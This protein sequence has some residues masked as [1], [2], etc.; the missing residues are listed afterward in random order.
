M[1]H[2][3]RTPEGWWEPPGRASYYPST[4]LG[5]IRISGSDPVT[6]FPLNSDIASHAAQTC[7]VLPQIQQMADGAAA[8]M[9]KLLAAKT[10]ELL[11]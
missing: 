1:Q 3:H 5:F 7:P 4:I 9:D 11:G 8:E 10:K 6:P 2:W